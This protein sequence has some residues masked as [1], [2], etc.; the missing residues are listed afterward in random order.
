MNIDAGIIT[1]IAMGLLAMSGAWI[2]A[3]VAIRSDL[4]RLHE[5]VA[6]SLDAANKAHERLDDLIK[7]CGLDRRRSCD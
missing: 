3:Y 7:N 2:G 4:A 5:R 6:A 1:N